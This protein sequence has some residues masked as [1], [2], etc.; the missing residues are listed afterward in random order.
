MSLKIDIKFP[1]HL[2]KLFGVYS[3]FLSCTSV[4]EDK[5]CPEAITNIAVRFT[6]NCLARNSS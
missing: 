1:Y 6:F 4:V 3:A 5:P 2:R